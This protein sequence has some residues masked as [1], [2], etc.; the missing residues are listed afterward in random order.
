MQP[1]L[2]E[3]IT[4]SESTAEQYNT[5]IA[6]MYRFMKECSTPNPKVPEELALAVLDYMDYLSVAGLGRSDWCLTAYAFQGASWDFEDKTRTL[7]DVQFRGRWRSDK[8]LERYCKSSLAQ[9][10]AAEVRTPVLE[11]GAMLEVDFAKHLLGF[12]KIP[13]P[14]SVHACA[15]SPVDNLT[16]LWVLVG[17][18]E[19]IKFFSKFSR[20][21]VTCPVVLK[22]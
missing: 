19:D 18:V 10:A 16:P 13:P 6:D 2:C 14:S 11:W 5:A 7:Q 9:A 15:A 4:I 17:R 22:L 3:R 20:A 12:Q 1:S 8:S 21:R